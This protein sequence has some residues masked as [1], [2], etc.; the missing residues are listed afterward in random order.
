MNSNVS[1]NEGAQ[2][3]FKTVRQ[4]AVHISVLCESTKSNLKDLDTSTVH[5]YSTGIYFA[6]INLIYLYHMP[7]IY[8]KGF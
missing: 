8:A 1:F 6:N 2:R 4:P 7:L 5:V 3:S